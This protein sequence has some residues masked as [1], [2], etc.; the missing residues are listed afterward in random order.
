M[1]FGTY[2]SFE[3]PEQ[4]T[5]DA[6]L[7]A[8]CMEKQ[9]LDL[10]FTPRTKKD[11]WEVMAV[12][13]V[14]G[15]K[16]ESGRRRGGQRA[17]EDSPTRPNK[18]RKPLRWGGNPTC[19]SGIL[20][21]AYGASADAPVPPWCW[22]TIPAH[23]TWTRASGRRSCLRYRA[24]FCAKAWG[25][26]A[27]DKRTYTYGDAR[28]ARETAGDDGRGGGRPDAPISGR[29]AAGPPTRSVDASNVVVR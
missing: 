5:Q 9:D 14:P 19:F 20:N 23:T 21:P 12:E 28:T 18:P 17:G 2:S 4:K 27:T 15:K 10:Y 16:Q 8:L 24:G 7:A 29:A 3:E 6:Q 13:F 25:P 11:D 22:C 1:A 26:C